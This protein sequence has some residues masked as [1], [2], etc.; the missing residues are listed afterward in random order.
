MLSSA[1]DSSCVDIYALGDLAR[2]V[3]ALM[4]A[5]FELAIGARV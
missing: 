1:F 5:H 3:L 2:D 4:V